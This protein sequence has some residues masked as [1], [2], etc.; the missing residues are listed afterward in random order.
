MVIGVIALLVAILLPSLSRSRENARAVVC[1]TQLNQW[2]KAMIMYADTFKGYLPFEER[3][4]TLPNR[5]GVIEDADG[6]RIWDEKGWICWYDCL[7]VQLGQANARLP[8]Q[9]VR[10]DDRDV[11]GVK[12]CPTVRRS[13]PMVEE[14]YRMNSKLAD[15]SR[16]KLDGAENPFYKPY[17]KIDTLDRPTETVLLFGA[18][19]GTGGDPT[20]EP[21]FKGRWEWTEETC[22]IGTWV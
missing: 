6:D 21:S 1:R 2:G 4:S 18:R 13:D 19:V 5:R 15:Y 17:R 10:A 7:D 8:R 9:G 22:S 20:A 16:T 12:V 14:S 11:A 3:P